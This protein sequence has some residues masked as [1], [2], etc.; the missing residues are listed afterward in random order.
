MLVFVCVGMRVCVKKDALCNGLFA[1]TT[2]TVG[3]RIH[4]I[5]FVPLCRTFCFDGQCMHEI[6]FKLLLDDFIDQSMPLQKQT[7]QTIY[8]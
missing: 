4:F 5:V 3:A 7:T 2:F 1:E 8:Q 6:T